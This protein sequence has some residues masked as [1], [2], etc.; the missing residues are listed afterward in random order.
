V[1]KGTVGSNPTLSAT[2][3]GANVHRPTGLSRFDI[4]LASRYHARG[5]ARRGASGALNPQT[6]IAGSNSSPRADRTRFCCG[7]KALKIG[8]CAAEA[9][10]PRQVREEAAVRSHLRVPQECLVRA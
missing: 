5:R 7:W 3:I 6:A 2:L 1:P 9:F 8:S 10:E 4:S